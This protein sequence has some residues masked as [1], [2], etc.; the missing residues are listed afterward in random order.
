MLTV[1]SDHV[2]RGRPDA[3]DVGLGHR[4]RDDALAVDERA[5]V[6][7]EVSDFESAPAPPQLGVVTRHA[8]V[9]DDDVVVGVPA[10][11]QHP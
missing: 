4:S 1:R 7:A 9:G 2:E 8:Q 11:S 10:D 5:V 6:A 3:D